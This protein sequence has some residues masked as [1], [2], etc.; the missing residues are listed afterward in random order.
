[1]TFL[2]YGYPTIQRGFAEL[3]RELFGPEENCAPDNEDIR[4]VADPS[5][6]S[7]IVAHHERRMSELKAHYEANP[8]GAPE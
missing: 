8:V 4:G 5:E 6:R 7:R 1:M 3:R 2:R